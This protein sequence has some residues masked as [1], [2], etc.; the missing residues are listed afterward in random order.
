[1]K[2]INYQ[3]HTRI[4][5]ADLYTPVG[6]FLKLRDLYQDT[7]M[8]ES[9]DFHAAD[10]SF[11]Y[12]GL[13]PLS[14]FSV[15]QG[16]TVIRAFHQ[17]GASRFA[18]DT[19]N[20]F[21]LFENYLGSFSEANGHQDISNGL[22]G[23]VSY[24]AVQHFD[25]FDFQIK[26]QEI[27]E[28]RFIFY[29]FVIA[30]NHFKDQ[31][32]IYENVPDGE[33]SRMEQ[34]LV[35]IKNRHVPVFP[36]HPSEIETS[37]CTDEYYLQMAEKGIAHCLRGDVFQ[38]VLSRRFS[39]KYTGD[40]FGVYRMLRTVNPSPYLF[41]FDYG[42]FRMFGSSPEAQLVVKNGIARINPIAGTFKRSGKDEEDRETA[43]RLMEDPKENA[44]HV[45]LVDLARNDLSR[46]ASEVT[47][48]KYRE[49]HYYSHV[50]HLVS[51]VSGKLNEKPNPLRLLADSFPAGTLS[52]APKHRAI[53]IINELEPH[54][55]GFYGGCAGFI[56]FN[57]DINTTI[58]I[59]T[60]LSLNNTLHYQAGAGV[61]AASSPQSEL[62]EVGH[63]LGALRKAI[64][65][66]KD[67]K[68]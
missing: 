29:R 46:H 18:L 38:V 58:T 31:L 5:P 42:D 19:H 20:V 6:I 34:L 51:Q 11:S 50:I 67:L 32:I 26:E 3:T 68:A 47:V 16:A 14:I 9:A 48:E 52:G 37:S 36:F 39:R 45:M 60:F 1:M 28:L 65:M 13:D 4:L 56:G 35:Q 33:D 2:P 57:G 40:D 12:I 10:N 23:Y 49:V 55:R 24:N 59:R 41:Y 15:E 66:A 25:Q 43:R 53:R 8:L 30:F 61:V 64:E 27:P 62:A 54:P 21:T 17:Q 22:L 44:E 7:V 63:K